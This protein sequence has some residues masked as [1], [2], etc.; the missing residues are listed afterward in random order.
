MS[1][2]VGL[3]V[4]V[5]AG[6]VRSLPPLPDGSATVVGR[7]AVGAVVGDVDR[8]EGAGARRRRHLRDELV[9]VADVDV[10]FARDLV[11]GVAAQVDLVAEVDVDE[12]VAA[13]EG[14]ELAA[15]AF[16]G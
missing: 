12:V 2:N 3:S 6:T 15:V 16:R 8:V 7:V 11:D 13:L 1:T 14:G 9:A 4:G 5:D 10:L